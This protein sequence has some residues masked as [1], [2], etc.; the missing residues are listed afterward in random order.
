VGI[1]LIAVDLDGTLLHTNKHLSSENIAALQT[2]MTA[3]IEVVVATGR[4][5]QGLDELLAA[6]PGIRYYITSNGARCF[7]RF[8]NKLLFEHLL[9]K[10]KGLEVLAVGDHF[11]VIK[12]VF[13]QGKGYE[14]AEDLKRL[15]SFHHIEEIISYLRATRVPV[16]DLM[17]Y[18]K[19]SSQDMDK[20]QLLFREESERLEAWKWINCL[21]GVTLVNSLHNNIEVTAANVNKGNTLQELGRYLQID[22]IDIMAFGDRS[23]D[24]SMIA[25]AGVGVAMGNAESEVQGVANL[26]APTNDENGVANIVMALLNKEE[27]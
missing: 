18:V 23:N 6:L 21:G 11:E 10:E 16:E 1:K 25:M 19:A 24:V 7:D 5:Q 14:N 12:E 4:P 2:A 8:Q 27:L 15:E 13:Y 26:I 17:A 9:P 22:M 3:G 20:V